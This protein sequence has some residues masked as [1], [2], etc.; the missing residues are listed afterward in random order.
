MGT[1]DYRSLSTSEAQMNFKLRTLF[2]AI[3]LFALG[4]GSVVIASPWCGLLLDAVVWCSVVVAGIAAI[5]T[6]GQS[7][8]FACG[9]AGVGL[10]YYLMAFTEPLQS[11]PGP[12]RIVKGAS[13]A[14]H[15]LLIPL[16]VR[17]Q[18]EPG[19]QPSFNPQN[20]Y[21]SIGPNHLMT[22]WEDAPRTHRTIDDLATLL[23]G[24]IGGAVAAWLARIGK[25][26]ASESR[27][28]PS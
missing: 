10:L 11:L 17:Q 8:A 19:F 18:T 16:H 21:W 28:L 6:T 2:I 5:A 9:F 20:S 15:E 3:G 14:V 23:F 25:D 24:C 1:V 7:R 13:D 4:C 22:G 26:N 12:Q 27:P